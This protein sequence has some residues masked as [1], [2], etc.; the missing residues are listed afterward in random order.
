MLASRLK[1][2]KSVGIEVA[3]NRVVC[4]G[5]SDRDLASITVEQLQSETGSKSKDFYELLALLVKQVEEPKE[6]KVVE[7]GSFESITPLEEPEEP[8]EESLGE[9]EEKPKRGRKKSK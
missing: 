9:A 7:S 5:Y 3:G 1:L 2:N 6:T 8:K 4:D